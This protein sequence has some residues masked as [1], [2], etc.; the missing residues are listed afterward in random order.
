MTNALDTLRETVLK[1]HST[2][3]SGVEF[4]NKER[5]QVCAALGLVGEAAECSELIK[6]TYEQ[7]RV[8]D[9][10]KAK[11][12]LS[13]TLYYA[14]LMCY[15]LNTTMEERI[16]ALE[17]KLKIRFPEGFNVESAQNRSKE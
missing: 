9:I 8:L 7:A 13:D 4:A 15:A 5:L 16:V 6:K 2:L 14:Q 12:E 10:E 11:L 1:T 17:R 3:V